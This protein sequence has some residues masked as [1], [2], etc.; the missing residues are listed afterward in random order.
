MLPMVQMAA[1]PLSRAPMTLALLIATLTGCERAPSGAGAASEPLAVGAPGVDFGTVFEGRVLE[2]AWELEVLAPVAVAAAKTDCGCTLAELGRVPAGPR[3]S[4]AAVPYELGTTLAPGERLH[5]RARYDTRGR[6]GPGVRAVTLTTSAGAPLA[7]TLAADVRPWLLAEPAE[8]EYARVLERQ[9]AERAFVVRSAAG[10]PFA[11][12]AT[13]A[14]LPRWVTVDLQPHAPDAAGRAARWD[15]AV[16]LGADVPRGSYSYPIELESDVPVPDS[17]PSARR[18]TVAPTWT[19]QVVG[20]VALSAPTLEFGVVG[21]DETVART[22]RLDSFDP[23]F[24]PSGASARLEPLVPGDA[25]PL[26]RT[27]RVHARPA[28]SSCE[29]EVTLA[30]LDAAVTGSFFAKLVVET[31]HPDLPRLDALVRGVRAPDEPVRGV[32]APD[33]TVRGVRAPDDTV[34]GVRAPEGMPR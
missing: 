18:F 5:V 21:G 7:L 34:R 28:G 10:E 3:G 14:A 9:T 6:R 4:P 33:D 26:E 16:T 30:G 20:P 24:V 25:L 27:A 31:G 17:G 12:H 8:L 32:R 11:L 23:G 2:H 1:P 29:F 15:V 19:L 13:R 22:V